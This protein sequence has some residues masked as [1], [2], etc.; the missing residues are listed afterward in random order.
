MHISQEKRDKI[1]QMLKT[2]IYANDA[3][4][5]AQKDALW[6][7]VSEFQD[8][9]V[10][11][12]DD[13]RPANLPPHVID[14]QGARPYSTPLRRASPEQRAEIL[15]QAKV[16]VKNKILFHADSEWAFPSIPVNKRD[17]SKRWVVDYRKLNEV[18]KKTFT[19]LET[20]TMR[21]TS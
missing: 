2:D 14:V 6:E 4:N 7:L 11:D 1:E 19:A 3:L 20:S 10:L 8:I 5:Q 21:W 9:F 17:G 18:T 13:L 16:M 15:R 12:T